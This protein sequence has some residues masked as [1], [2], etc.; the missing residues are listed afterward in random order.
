MT[1]GRTNRQDASS[2]LRFRALA[3]DYD[4]TIATDGR[5]D[6]SVQDAL[7]QFRRS[8]RELLLATGR[9]LEELRAVFPGVRLF[10][11][12]VLEN[13]AVV[14]DPETG[15]IEE[16]APRAPD[17]FILRLRRRGVFP[18]HIG[19]VIVASREPHGT[20][21]QETIRELGLDLHLEFNRDAIMALPAGVT[22]ASGLDAALRQ[23]K[24]TWEEVVG[25]GDAQN[26][27][28]FLKRC[29]RS[30]AVAN[31]L[32]ALKSSVDLVTRLSEGAGV[33]ELVGRLL[34]GELAGLPKEMKS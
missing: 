12:L 16:L 4:A 30:V 34:S 21:M 15:I 13:G 32:P 1:A 29:G 3:C 6:P 2:S 9:T 17:E 5:V 7:H 27:E 14:L 28:S 33:A 25:V 11:R 23:V 18:L 31:A 19:R 26:D 8:G 20:V 22:K 10:S 24:V